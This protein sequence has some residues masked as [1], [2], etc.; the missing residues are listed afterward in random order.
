MHVLDLLSLTQAYIDWLNEQ[1]P[2]SQ[3][4]DNISESL[5]DGTLMLKAL[6]VSFQ[7]L[8]LCIH[9]LPYADCNRKEST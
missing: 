5:A 2:P 3:A 8:L 1:L 7:L 4:V 6:S 9:R